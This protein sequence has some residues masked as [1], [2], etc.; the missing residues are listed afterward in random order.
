MN[1]CH[2][3]QFVPGNEQVFSADVTRIR[4]GSGVLK[5]LGQEARA[6]GIKRAAVYTDSRIRSLPLFEEAVAALRAEGIEAVIYD[7]VRVEPTDVSFKEAAR[8]ATGSAF[9]GFISIG[10]GSVID[11]AKAANLYS[12]CRATS[13]TTSMRRSVAAL[14]SLDRSVLT[15]RV[16][17][18]QGREVRVP[19]LLYLIFWR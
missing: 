3:Y 7:E 19:A 12:S 6:L 5:E 2:H 10:G 11:T 15:L 16:Q 8:F 17:L 1:C 9:D 14:L 4:Y 13:W 18:L